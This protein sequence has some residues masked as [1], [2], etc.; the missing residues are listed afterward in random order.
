MSDSE[1]IVG[2]VEKADYDLWK[3]GRITNLTVRR[4]KA[5]LDPQDVLVDVSPHG[6]NDLL[7][8]ATAFIEELKAFGYGETSEKALPGSFDPFR[9]AVERMKG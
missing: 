6:M 5:P 2:R 8:T 1:P 7:R 3:E 4:S 9:D